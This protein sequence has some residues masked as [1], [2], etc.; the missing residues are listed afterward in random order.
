MQRSY[1]GKN[2]GAVI[3]HVYIYNLKVADPLN[4]KKIAL[5]SI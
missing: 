2:Q 4:V 5:N 3:M 1:L